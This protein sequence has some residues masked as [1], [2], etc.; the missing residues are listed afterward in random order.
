MLLTQLLRFVVPPLLLLPW[1]SGIPQPAPVQ[2]R[3]SHRNRHLHDELRGGKCA[4]CPH[5][6]DVVATSRSPHFSRDHGTYDTWDAME[7]FH[8]TRSE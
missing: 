3:Y 2:Q 8:A 4:L 5:H 1:A 6:S 7:A